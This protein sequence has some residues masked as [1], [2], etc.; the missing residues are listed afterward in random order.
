MILVSWKTLYDTTIKPNDKIDIFPAVGG[1]SETLLLN[2]NFYASLRKIS[3]N[4]TVALELPY[5]STIR[6]LLQGILIRFPEM[7]KKLLDQ[8]GELDR[9]AHIFIN[10]RNC[11]LLSQGLETTIGISDTVDIFPIGHF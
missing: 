3:G 2:V 4:K 6:Q 8:D 7:S 10:G 1:G 9:R 5:G 11:P